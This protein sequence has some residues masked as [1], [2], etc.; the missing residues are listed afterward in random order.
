MSVSVTLVLRP[1]H[2]PRRRPRSSDLL[3][4]EFRGGFT[5]LVMT[6]TGCFIQ[7]SLKVVYFH[8]QRLIDLLIYRIIPD[9]FR[10]LMT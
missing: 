2:S 10:I 6:F 9:F 7:L 1:W 8:G 3:R 5:P 4:I